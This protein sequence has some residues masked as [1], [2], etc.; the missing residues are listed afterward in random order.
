MKYLNYEEV[1]GDQ[2]KAAD[3]ESQAAD[4]N[5]D[6]D[7]KRDAKAIE[8]R[9]GSGVRQD[10]DNATAH[11]GGDN[12]QRSRSGSWNNQR[13]GSRGEPAY[14]RRYRQSGEGR[15]VDRRSGEVYVQDVDAQQRSYR[16]AGSEAHEL[17]SVRGS[18]RRM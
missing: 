11:S 18:G 17:R 2:D 7:D 10:S 9:S 3:E 8:R 13:R 16:P 14:D 1:N 15:P 4:E 6:N 12:R 5:H